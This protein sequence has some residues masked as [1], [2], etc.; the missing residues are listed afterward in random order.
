M[1]REQ[2]YNSIILKKTPFNE[3]DEII[4][5]LTEE[6]GK[7]RFLAKSVKLASSKLQNNLQS[8]FLCNLRIANSKSGK[9]SKIIGSEPKEIF[10]NL[11]LSM[12]AIKAAYSA[13]EITI[14]F[15]PD[16]QPSSGIYRLLKIFLQFLNRENLSESEIEAGLL[17]FKIKFLELSGFGIKYPKIESVKSLAF[18]TS[19]GGFVQ[20]QTALGVPVSK[21]SLDLFLALKQ[22]SFKDLQ[23]FSGS[24][25]E[26]TS[27]TDAFLEYQ[28]EREL[29]AEKSMRNVV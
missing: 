20:E 3:A 27:L 21:G 14:K 19:R 28:L 24:L 4:T 15:L 5:V 12:A 22:V 17:S 16:E 8:L 13:A 6:N 18:D 7:V 1:S 25:A 11:R 23:K 2:N 10:S 9:L 26:V 29:K